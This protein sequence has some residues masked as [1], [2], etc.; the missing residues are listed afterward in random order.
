MTLFVELIE[1]HNEQSRTIRNASVRSSSLRRFTF[2]EVGETSDCMNSNLICILLAGNYCDDVSKINGSWMNF[3]SRYSLNRSKLSLCWRE[4]EFRR[5]SLSLLHFC[6]VLHYFN[7][8][9]QPRSQG[10]SSYRPLGRARRDPGLVW[11]RAT[12]TIENIREG[13]SVIRQF[14]A[15]SFVALRPPLPA[16]D[17]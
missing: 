11:S 8:Y 3:W 12:M 15:L 2:D 13:S 16:R 6:T 9:T 1:Y 10:L 14:A 17:V 5:I 4:D 7:P